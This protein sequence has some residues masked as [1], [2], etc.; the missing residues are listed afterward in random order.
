MALFLEI[1]R[2]V[3]FTLWPLPDLEKLTKI[4]QWQDLP[5]TRFLCLFM[6]WLVLNFLQQPLQTNT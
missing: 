1:A 5:D 4:F 6:L 3:L 2:N